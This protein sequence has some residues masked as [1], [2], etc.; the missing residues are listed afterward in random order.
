LGNCIKPADIDGDGDMDF[1]VGNL[2]QNTKLKATENQ[3]AEM[4]TFDADKNGT[5]EQVITCY[6]E[7]GK[8]Y[9]MVLKHELQKAV[10]SIKMKFLKFAEY[11]GKAIDEVFSTEQLSSA[12]TRKATNNNTSILVNEGNFKFTLKALPVEAQYSPIYAIE[13]MD[14]NKDGKLDILLAGNFY[15]VLPE[16]GRYDANYGLVLEGTGKG[17]F[18]SV[19]SKDSG[20]LV[21]GQVRKMQKV[22]SLAG[23][24]LIVVAKNNDNAQVFGVK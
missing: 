24:E 11:A 4:Y 10:P 1:I 21:K 19:L 12:I 7:D 13:T 22:K 20:F 2:G 9:P 6:T 5:L 3:P 23:K 16:V 14:Y 8:T 17:N 18:K 15:D